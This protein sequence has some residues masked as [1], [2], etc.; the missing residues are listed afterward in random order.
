[1]NESIAIIGVAFELPNIKTWPDLVSSLENK[2]TFIQPLSPNR[3]QDIHSRFGEIEMA[4]AGYLDHLDLFD[5]EYFGLSKREAVRTFPEHRYFLMH[6][7]RAFYDAGYTREDLK[8]SNTGIFYA[9]AQSIYTKFLDESIGDF[10]GMP[11]IE[12]TKLATFL[13]LRGPVMAIYTTCSS[14]LVA[15][16]SACVSLQN[17]ESDMILVGGSKFSANTIGDMMANVVMSKTG[18]CRPFDKAANGMMNGEG[19]IF[20]VLKRLADAEKDNDPVYGV[21]EGSAVNHGGA[22]IASLTAP[23]SEA[24]KD[25]IIK[26]WEN[27]K[28]D[29]KEIRFIEAHGTG[30]IL[31]DPIEY[32]AISDAFREKNISGT[33]CS[34]SSFKGQ[35]GH[36]DTMA[37]LAGLLRL[38]AA[39][40]AQVL[41]V[42]ANFSSI[43]EHIDEANSNVRVQ[44]EAAHWP[45]INGVRKGGVSSFGMTGTN[46]HVIVSKKEMAAGTGQHAPYHF[47]QISESSKE[48][49]R[50]LKGEMARYIENNG[51]VDLNLFSHKVNRLFN[52]DKY[53]EGIVFANTEE[54]LGQL[55]NNDDAQTPV[56]TAFFLL[57]LDIL[58]YDADFVEEILQENRIIN[59]HW[60]NLTGNSCRPSGI[61]DK[62]VLSVLFQFTLYKYLVS[63]SGNKIQV[64]T[65]QGE[66]V[67]QQ[68]VNNKITA[69]DIIKDPALIRV[70]A[71]QF[72]RKG[73][74]GYLVTKY[75]Q[76]KI[77]IIDFSREGLGQFP[78]SDNI[79]TVSGTWEAKERFRLYKELLAIHATPLKTANTPFVFHGWQLPY[80]EL[81]RVWP[82]NTRKVVTNNGDDNAA[83]ISK[84][85]PA[86]VAPAKILTLEEVQ[87]RVKEVWQKVLDINEDIAPADDFFESGGDSI[88][89]LD[90]LSAIDHEFRG[91]FVA[92]EEMYSFSTLEKLSATLYNRLNKK[93]ETVEKQVKETVEEDTV[94]RGNRYAALK[95][96][97]QNM[98]L[99]GS[100]SHHDILVTGATGL[101]GSF[102]VKYLVDH[103]GASV[104]CLVRG[105]NR[106]DAHDRFW[107]VYEGNFNINNHER[108]KV[109]CGDLLQENIFSDSEAG[110]L[111]KGVDMV[112]H[113]AGSAS[114][115]G[116]QDLEENINYK[117][118]RHI[119]DWAVLNNI[120]YFNYISTIGIVGNGMPKHIDAFYETDVDLGQDTGHLVH[121]ATKLMAEKY[122][123]SKKP[124]SVVVNTFRIP[125][126]G[127]RYSDGYS[128]IDMSRNL[129]YLKLQTIN[130][131]GQYSD[132]FLNYNAQLMMMP[133]DILAATICRLSFTDQRLLNTFHL[134]VEKSF[135]MSEI[136][137]AFNNN[138]V[139]LLKVDD[140]VF[141]Q[142]VEKW[143]ETS[144]DYTT[145]L[146]KYGTYDKATNSESKYK[147]ISDATKLLLK[148]IDMDVDYDRALYLNNIVNYCTKNGFLK[149]DRIFSGNIPA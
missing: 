4:K 57:D 36:L 81:Q 105:K 115:V 99:P 110:V 146:L 49:L 102:L 93:N 128:R 127:G 58:H 7:L 140:E 28:V 17:R 50:K 15:V 26:A 89:G 83:G 85:I 68:L 78:G 104:I 80:Y 23:S 88:S 137:F 122:I 92:Y 94:T 120:K 14:S 117:G 9:A 96:T 42:Q 129:M 97:I 142:H 27:A 24:Q 87:T 38:I 86:N 35:V 41:P 55:N 144:K 33:T 138:G 134:V 1:M 136:I 31:G 149:S 116:S 133:V 72:D 132:E 125:N 46:V 66:S 131:L 5:R 82:E 44:R 143:K 22:R 123:N 101:L 126:M 108:I 20:M 19:T 56:P 62:D 29:P 13:D 75:L 54:L 79:V 64:I 32:K 69:A 91:K 119:F 43:N 37:G 130:K 34:I 16:H 74:E 60:N 59:G 6:A 100:I 61:Q 124:S 21:I 10:D 147:V 30:T 103:T 84:T 145:S 52:T 135:T 53:A 39:L 107:T 40:N 73:F 141:T 8:G 113:V 48:R 12:A 65:K 45:A 111:L 148:A 3:V 118:T 139:H 98:A 114:Y 67:L 70:N 90:M 109:V 25:L 18:Q 95:D 63:L 112:Y 47:I 71:H 121:A 2:D 77:V 106:Q 11:G 51:P 76:Q